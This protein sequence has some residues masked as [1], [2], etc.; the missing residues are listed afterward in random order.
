[1]KKNYFKILLFTLILFVFNS[2]K[3]IGQDVPKIGQ[4][5][6]KQENLKRGSQSSCDC[7]GTGFNDDEEQTIHLKAGWNLISFDVSPEDKTIENVFD[8]VNGNLAWISTFDKG[9]K[10]Y[11]PN[12]WPVFNTL[13]EIE[14]G[15]GY[16]VNMLNCDELII[17]GTPIDDCF[18]RQLDHG[19]NLVAYPS[20]S[21][22]SPAIYFESLIPDND[23]E[24]LTTTLEFVS[25][26]E[27]GSGTKTYD[28]NIYPFLNSLTEM[29]NGFGY[30][31]RVNRSADINVADRAK[32]A[33]IGDFGMALRD[34]DGIDANIQAVAT[35]VDSW[36]PDF[37]ITTGDNSYE[38][39]ENPDNIFDYNVG[40][41]YQ[42]YIYPYDG[43]YGNGSPTGE[44]RFFPCPGNHDYESDIEDGNVEPLYYQY[45]TLPSENEEKYYDFVKGNVHLFSLN[46]NDHHEPGITA[47]CGDQYRWLQSKLT[48]STSKYKIVYF[49]HPPFSSGPKGCHPEMNWP[50]KDWGAT[51]V[52]VGDN[53]HYERLEKD[54]F[55]YFVNGAGASA[56]S[57]TNLCDISNPNTDCC[58]PGNNDVISMEIVG[59]KEGAMLIE[60]L[61]N[62]IKFEFWAVSNNGVPS[63]QMIIYDAN[64]N[65]KLDASIN[66][67]PSGGSFSGLSVLFNSF[68]P[69]MAGGSI[70]YGVNITE[71]GRYNLALIDMSG[72]V[73]HSEQV[74]YAFEGAQKGSFKTAD[75]PSGIY[76]LKMSNSKFSVTEKVII[77]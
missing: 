50:F 73:L 7:G 4:D 22:Q 75:L 53:H 56:Y 18:I 12:G 9:T 13:K 19:W 72:K 14:D 40:Q 68:N 60:E 67:I 52:L 58:L 38:I 29:K 39:D 37:V 33:V 61:N 69:G 8:S 32:F 70:H 62:G 64:I 44:N 11:N 31:V 21:P 77:H 17:S 71:S 27:C 15:F 41:Y 2:S 76:V 48:N 54:G 66:G 55:P 36:S 23:T 3:S 43:E 59:S 63:D 35:L 20:D 57:D 51:A 49:H 28:P 74:E 16:W 30:W 34:A 1:M 24:N 65:S 42:K 6:S 45:F 5:M 10:T 47:A 26:F 25:S 46:S